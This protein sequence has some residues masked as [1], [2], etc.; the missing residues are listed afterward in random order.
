MCGRRCT[1]AVRVYR[2]K[3]QGLVRSRRD[4]RGAPRVVL[5]GSQTKRT[6]EGYAAASVDKARLAHTE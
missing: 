3:Q 4:Q 5:Q 6:F 1:Q 2:L